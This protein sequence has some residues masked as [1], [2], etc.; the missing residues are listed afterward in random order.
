MLFR[1]VTIYDPFGNEVWAR[2][3][4]QGEQGGML[5]DNTVYWDGTNN[6]GQRVATGVYLIQVLGTLHTG[7][8]FRSLYRVGV[9]W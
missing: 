5:G 2:H 7:V 4:N 1:S 3:Y 6:K 9:V 8:D